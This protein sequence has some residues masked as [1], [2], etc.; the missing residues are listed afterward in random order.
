MPRRLVLG[1][2]K[3]LLLGALMAF[4]VVRGLGAV[5]A[6][7]AVSYLYAALTGVVTALLAGKPVWAAGA[8]VEALLKAIFGALLALGANFALG[9]WFHPAL[10]LTAFGAGAGPLNALPAA[11]LPLM[12]AA[13]GAFFELDNTPGPTPSAD[14]VVKRRVASDASSREEASDVEEVED[15]SE[16]QNE[17]RRT[18]R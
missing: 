16:T 18:R 14:A 11:S 4:L 15:R 13:L 6:V 10:D 5:T 12:A 9:R 8:K 2:F 7:G 17:S 3:G 1:L